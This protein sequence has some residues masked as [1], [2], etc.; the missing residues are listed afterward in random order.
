MP[1]L[2][3]PRGFPVGGSRVVGWLKSCL[4]ELTSDGAL[5]QDY[6]DSSWQPR[7]AVSYAVTDRISTYA[8]ASRG[9]KAGGFNQLLAGPAFDPETIWSYEVGVKGD[10]YDG[11]LRF[12]ASAFYYEYSDLQVLVDF[13]GSVLTRNAGSATGSGAEAQLTWRP[14]EAFTLSA[15]A[16][17][18][19]AT[20]EDF[21]PSAEQDFSGNRLPRAPEFSTSIVADAAVPVGQGVE[22]LGRAEYSYRSRQFFDPSNSAF[23]MQDGYALVNA[24]GGVGWGGRYQLRGFVQNV[25]DDEYLIDTATTVPG[26]LTYTQRGEPRTYG[27]QLTVRY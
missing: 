26:L 18:L 17:Y 23:E 7:A 11:R 20:Y 14:V 9:F 6:R 27:V 25:F 19:D 15:G 21:R 4:G 5:R 1:W 12:D 10:A 16:A 13:A 2:P 22:L 24:S 3:S 8:L